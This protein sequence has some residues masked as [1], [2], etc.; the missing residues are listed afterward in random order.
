[1]QPIIPKAIE[2]YC[3]A[4]SMSPSALRVELE[5]YT[6]AHCA[7]PQMLTGALEAAFLQML[8]R[9]AGA[10][11]VVEIGLYTGYSA[12]AMAEALPEDGMLH[13]CEID[14][15]RARIARGFFERSPHGRKITVHL[16]EAL[17]V[18]PALLP[19]AGPLDLV[20]I[21][22]DKENYGAYYDLCLPHVRPGGL[23]VV[24]N[25]L[26]SG[27]VLAPERETDRAIAAFNER[28]AADE[29]VECVM[30]PLRDG[31]LLARK[32]PC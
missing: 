3:A 26:W 10:R 17:A 14:P 16:G 7:E 31:V 21:D 27:R 5:R 20:F 19:A 15:E 23:I 18:L 4:H 8:V 28:L 12:L 32:R 11:R 6:R 29:R 24:D 13:S 1:M 30:L 25:V 2:E 22:A 9:L